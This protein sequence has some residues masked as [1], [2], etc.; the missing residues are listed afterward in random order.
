MYCAKIWPP[1]PNRS[2]SGGT[3][4]SENGI[5]S[6]QIVPGVL[7]FGYVVALYVLHLP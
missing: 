3:I 2:P 4:L 5:H 1:G 7:I 6:I